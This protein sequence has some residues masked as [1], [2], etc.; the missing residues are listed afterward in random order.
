MAFA[1]GSNHSMAYVAE[2]TYGVT[3]PTPSFKPFRHTGT[4]LALSKETLQS[5]ELRDDRQIACFRHGNKQVGG[6]V[7][8]ELCYTDFD[9]MLEAV[10]CGTWADDTPIAGTDTLTAGTTRRSFTIERNFA[11]IGERIRYTGCEANTFNVSVAPNAIVTATF[12]FVG[13]DQDSDNS[14]ITGATYASTQGG[15][16][17]D[18]F[19]G[20]ILLD[21]VS[22]GIIT[23][24]DVSLENGIEPSF[25]VG[26]P[27]TAGNTIGRSNVT[28]TLTAY[29]ESVAL[30]NKF[31]NEEAVTVQFSLVSEAGDTLTFDLPNVK[32][33]SGQP[34]VSGDGSVTI[35]L[36]MQALYDNGAQSNIVITRTPA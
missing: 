19:S 35:A 20:T 5:E 18:S 2:S 23:Q 33:G 4:T 7:N 21:G 25:V 10:L 22:T 14:M 16:P 32:F 31:V 36:D 9:D 26:S 17:F 15:C 24:I 34:D 27:T 8:S 29:F 1:S 6:D 12:G 11:D 30:L 28:G 3:P 13:K